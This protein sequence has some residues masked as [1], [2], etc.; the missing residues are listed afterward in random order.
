MISVGPVKDIN[1]LLNLMSRSLILFLLNDDRC[2]IELSE[3][4]LVFIVKWKLV[5]KEEEEFIQN[6][7]L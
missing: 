4:Q 1:L 7:N 3:I 5:Y 2:N 6:R